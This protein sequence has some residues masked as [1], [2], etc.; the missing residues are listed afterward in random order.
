MWVSTTLTK[1]DVPWRNSKFSLSFHI[2]IWVFS[3]PVNYLRWVVV[4][5]SNRTKT[6]HNKDACFASSLKLHLSSFNSMLCAASAHNG[7][8]DLTHLSE[9]QCPPTLRINSLLLIFLLIL[10]K[11]HSDYNSATPSL[12]HTLI[13]P[14]KQNNLFKV[15]AIGLQ[16]FPFYL[17]LQ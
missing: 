17:Y 6:G 12:T 16:Q 11:R 13:Q 1:T 7:S 9:P 3:H 5:G 10:C 15:L 14:N 8:R 2:I 4:V